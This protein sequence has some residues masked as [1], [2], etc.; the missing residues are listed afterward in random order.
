VLRKRRKKEE[1]THIFV[2]EYILEQ[3]K[4]RE[5]KKFEY[6]AKLCLLSELY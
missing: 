2:F 3:K 1:E 6:I 4:E 5:E